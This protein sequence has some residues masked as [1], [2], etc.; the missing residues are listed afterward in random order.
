MGLDMTHQLPLFPNTDD[1]RITR[2]AVL[3]RRV[4]IAQHQ[5]KAAARNLKEEMERQA[6]DVTPP[7]RSVPP[8]R[9]FSAIDK[10][11]STDQE[12]DACV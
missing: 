3:Q 7:P 2:L 6:H 1:A 5:L 12:P 4:E 9:G 11:G 10:A 8:A